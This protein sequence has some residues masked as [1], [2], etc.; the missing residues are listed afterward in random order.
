QF[1]YDTTAPSTTVVDSFGD[2]FD[3]SS[4]YTGE[5]LDMYLSCTD[6]PEYGLGCN[7]TYYCLDTIDCAPTILYEITDAIPVENET[8][9]L[10]YYSNENIINGAGGLEETIHCTEIK[11]DF[12]DPSLT[13][14]SPTDGSSVYLPYVT[15][16]GT[17]ND[18]DTTSTP[19]NTA[20]ITVRNTEGNESTYTVDASSGFSYTVP[21]TLET[22]ET[23]YNYITIYGTDRS[24]AITAPQ[25]IGV[26]Y[27][28][29]LGDD[30]IWIVSP[31][32]GVSTTSSFTFTV[33]TYLEADDCGYSKNNVSREKS[34]P[35]TASS[36]DSSAHQYSASYT[37]D[38]SKQGIG[39][40]VYVKCLLTNGV[41]YATQFILEYDSTA[42]VIEKLELTNSDG[43]TPPS[44][45]EAPLNAQINVTTD[46]RTKCKYSFDSSDGFNT[47]MTK[48]TNY[49]D[50][51]YS[52]MNNDTFESLTD[53]TLYT[54][55][56][57]CQNGAYLTSATS[58]LS[59]TVNTSAA[60]DIYLISPTISGSR[61][62]TVTIGTTRT[63]TSCSYGT[64]STSIS[65]A[66]T[67]V[68]DK[69]F[70]T[71]NNTVSTDGNYTY[72]FSC[73]FADGLMTNYFT[74]PVDTSAPVI[75]F[76]EDGNTSSSNT[77][78]SAT[79]SASDSITDI[80]LYMYSV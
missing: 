53:N 30:A 36:S 17:V 63:A 7:Q 57:A 71:A 12:Y 19:I 10:C 67:L 9:V 65:T 48:F 28:T 73:W 27:T 20:S 16:T 47:G 24:G 54:L 77:T 41:E 75:D 14:T 46:D 34:M 45:I 60:S 13:I 56:V 51:E 18:P 40:Y 38:S 1:T 58:L 55:Y 50:N 52:T 25:T 62:F 68:T 39:E 37:I 78:L 3:F 32:N 49:D 59:F 33:G 76:I 6:S 23:T 79:W 26:R 4:F 42:P 74:I 70:K 66:M 2:A 29:E 61:S 31:S 22:N 15:I 64:N 69:Q 72:Y 80:V 35:L 8:T 21:L 44:I 43:K 5:D 11:V